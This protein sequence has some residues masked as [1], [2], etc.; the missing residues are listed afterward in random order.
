[1][2]I[3]F[4]TSAAGLWNLADPLSLAL[5]V[6]VWHG[7]GLSCGRRVLYSGFARRLQQVCGTAVPWHGGLEQE[8]RSRGSRALRLPG[9]GK[10]LRLWA[11][12]DGRLAM[13]DAGG[14]PGRIPGSS[15][16]S[17]PAP[18][19]PMAGHC[20]VY[21]GPR[22]GIGV[23][24]Y[25]LPSLSYVHVT[26][27]F[28]VCVSPCLI[29]HMCMAPCIYM[30]SALPYVCAR[31]LALSY[32]CACSW[33]SALSCMGVYM[34]PVGTWMWTRHPA[35]SHIYSPLSCVCMVC[36]C[37]LLRPM[38]V[39]LC[40]RVQLCVCVRLCVRVRLCVHV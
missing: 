6:R 32:M 26:P 7:R 14:I 33:H 3:Q 10:R 2:C 1:M 39:W 5:A 34:V 24:M 4:G 19:F 21:M 23:G 13:Q 36:V 35:L 17:C 31:H 40:V 30:A 37:H 22:A 15:G 38:R 25:R 27:C 8:Q 29:I 16:P 18:G 20:C 11:R 28:V 9:E 12:S